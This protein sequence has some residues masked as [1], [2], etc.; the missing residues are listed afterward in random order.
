MGMCNWEKVKAEALKR[1]DRD[2]DDPTVSWVE[3]APEPLLNY[4]SDSK[5]GTVSNTGFVFVKSHGNNFGLHLHGAL[6]LN[7]GED[8]YYELRERAEKRA[9]CAALRKALDLPSA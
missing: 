6:I 3:T 4:S 7:A 1:L 2:L 5:F 9:K 8:G